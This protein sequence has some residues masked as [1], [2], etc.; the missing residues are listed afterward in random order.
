MGSLPSI[1]ELTKNVQ[2][3]ID[4][5]NAAD[6][7]VEVKEEEGNK[8]TLLQEEEQEIKE[9]KVVADTKS[10]SLA[11]MS[12]VKLLQEFGERNVVGT[13]EKVSTIVAGWNEAAKMFVAQA[14]HEEL[15]D[16]KDSLLRLIRWNG[17]C[18]P[19]PVHKAAKIGAVKLM[20][21]LLRTSFD[22]NTKGDFEGTAWHYACL[23]GK[24][25]TAQLIIETSKEF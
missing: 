15:Q 4:K 21:F 8:L 11:R 24:T 14:S 3:L 20:E 25:E 5:D 2:N 17:K 16:V 18:C 1:E 12:F 10:E 13:N 9:E 7:I 22:M 6:D 23:T 19:Y